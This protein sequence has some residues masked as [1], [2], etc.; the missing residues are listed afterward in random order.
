VLG[1][2]SSEEKRGEAVVI[3]MDI[4]VDIQGFRDA[5]KNFIPKEIAVF[6][7]NA[8]YVGHWITMPPYPFDDLPESSRRENN[9]LSRN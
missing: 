3:A 6:A 8:P 1:V 5:E 2:T 4:V 9:W 7:I